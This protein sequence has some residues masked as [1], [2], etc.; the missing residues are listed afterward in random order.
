MILF[1]TNT[2]R[3][4]RYQLIQYR[5]P[6]AEKRINPTPFCLTSVVF[7]Y[8]RFLFQFCWMFVCMHE[9]RL[10]F[11]SVLV[12]CDHDLCFLIELGKI[13]FLKFTFLRKYLWF[14][15]FLVLEM[16]LT[17]FC[18]C[19]LTGRRHGDRRFI[20]WTRFLVKA[21]WLNI[22]RS[23]VKLVVRVLK[24]GTVLYKTHAH[25]SL[26]NVTFVCFCRLIYSI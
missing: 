17:G 18:R 21:S 12:A 8:W 13:V 24:S 3:C 19:L 20:K 26:V 11:K 16:L 7:K 15:E 5:P 23:A 22:R 6:Y 14:A 1:L 2:M 9:P 10:Q 4:V 25:I